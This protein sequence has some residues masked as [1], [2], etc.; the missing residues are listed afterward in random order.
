MGRRRAA[1]AEIRLGRNRR[2]QSAVVGQEP[3]FAAE[4]KERMELGISSI[5]KNLS[6]IGWPG[7]PDHL[8]WQVLLFRIC[9][10]MMGSASA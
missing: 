5:T 2:V 6:M 1:S 9:H 8:R 4:V 3:P 10:T 7:K